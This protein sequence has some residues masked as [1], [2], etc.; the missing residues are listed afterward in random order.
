VP[1]GGVG[2]SVGGAEGA[3]RG[4]VIRVAMLQKHPREA[5]SNRSHMPA[6]LF[7]NEIHFLIILKNDFR[8]NNKHNHNHNHNDYNNNNILMPI[9]TKSCAYNLRVLIILASLFEA[10]TNA[11]KELKL[12]HYVVSN[13]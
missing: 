6:S 13:K 7:E 12:N 2:G 4:G 1:E 9:K 10:H 11:V 8:Y 3:A 5:A